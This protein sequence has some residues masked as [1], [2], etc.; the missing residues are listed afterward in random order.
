MWIWGLEGGAGSVKPAPR[1]H[2][3]HAHEHHGTRGA[4]HRVQGTSSAASNLFTRPS[5][6]FLKRHLSKTFSNASVILRLQKG[7]SLKQISL[8]CLF[9]K[10]CFLAL[11]F[12][13]RI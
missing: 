3:V 5:S 11:G 7:D 9:L 8:F 4:Q 12:E 13:W 6:S 1:Q 2:E 10:S